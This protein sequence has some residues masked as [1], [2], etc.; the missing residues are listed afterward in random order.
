MVTN[1]YY[2]LPP[3][4]GQIVDTFRAEL[5]LQDLKAPPKFTLLDSIPFTYSAFSKSSPT[6]VVYVGGAFRARMWRPPS[7]EPDYVRFIREMA[8]SCLGLLDENFDYN[9]HI[10]S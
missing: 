5:L 7:T 6:K 4:V 8:H 10:W 1:L 2:D 9:R 3:D